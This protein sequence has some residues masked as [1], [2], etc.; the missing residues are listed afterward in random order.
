MEKQLTNDRKRVYDY[1]FPDV[2][3]TGSTYKFRVLRE[4]WNMTVSTGL[5]KPRMKGERTGWM[6]R[7]VQSGK[8]ERHLPGKR[9]S[10]Y[11]L[12]LL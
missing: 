12:L 6:K 3:E 1:Q 10:A 9:A 5:P 11:H 4:S 2:I 8:Q 7:R